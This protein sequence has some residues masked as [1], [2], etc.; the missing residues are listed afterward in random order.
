MRIP[1]IAIIG[2][3]N[4]AI[5]LSK[6]LEQGGLS[7]VSVTGRN[8]SKAQAVASQ[9]YTAEVH[10]GLDFS[11][12]EA[13]LFFLCVADSAIEELASQLML[14]KHALLVHCAGAVPLSIFEGLESEYGVFYPA[15]T[16]SAKRKVTFQEVPVCLEAS[17][18]NAER[19]LEQVV[20]KIGAAPFF[21]N[22]EQRLTLHLSAVFACNFT[23][24]FFAIAQELLQEQGLPFELLDTL[25]RETVAKALEL[26]PLQ[27]QTG[28][29][30]RRDYATIEKHETLLK[31]HPEWLDLYQAI[32][33]RILK[34][35]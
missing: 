33:R 26:G 1:P 18:E 15:Q 17:S 24:H 12:S 32:S 6:A 3:G 4:L 22:S 19:L 14:P 16:F 28:P 5:H 2:T 9:L 23:N 10:K 35:H 11:T 27:S 7:V 25:I 34:S 31:E 30:I 29:A 20:E 21:L 8:V 13:R